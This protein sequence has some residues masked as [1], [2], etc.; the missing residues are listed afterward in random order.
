[1]AITRRE[2]LA[3]I[4]ALTALTAAGGLGSVAHAARERLIP[5]R[6]WS[7]GQTCIPAARVAPAT[8]AELASVVKAASSGVRAVGSSHSFS[9]L[10]P[11][12]G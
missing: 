4:G 5:W 1:M 9:A 12:N 3:Q 7:G 11:T 10:I 6:N 2:L 8:E